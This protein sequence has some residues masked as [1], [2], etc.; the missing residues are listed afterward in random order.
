MHH[1]LRPLPLPSGRPDLPST[2]AAAA[3]P[4]TY[5][6]GLV[7]IPPYG[8]HLPS[9]CHV[10]MCQWPLRAL[11]VRVV[12]SMPCY[13]KDNVDQQRGGGVFRRSIAGL[14][15][16]NAVGYSQLGTGLILD[17]VYNPGG[18]FLAPPQPTLEP[19]YKQELREAHGIEFNSLLCL[20]NMPIKRFWDYLERRGELES[21]MRL[22]TEAFNADAGERLMC[23]DT[24]S[25]AWDGKLCVTPTCALVHR[26]KVWSRLPQTARCTSLPRKSCLAI[27]ARLSMLISY[28]GMIVT[29]ISSWHSVSK[30]KQLAW[31]S[32][33]STHLMSSMAFGSHVGIIAMVVQP[34]QAPLVKGSDP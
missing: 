5:N 10:A 27:L 17:L 34:V 20:N 9:I 23:R 13:S 6:L 12:A 1:G 2:V 24:V 3:D 26:P 7:Y 22:L 33:R 16:L 14:Q 19:A 15:K 30:A 31:M 8:R 18:A 25:V 28:A 21:Y 32:I 11:Q 29:S 4:C